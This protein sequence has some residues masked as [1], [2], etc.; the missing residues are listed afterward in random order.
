VIRIGEEKGIKKPGAL[1]V[2]K[3]RQDLNEVSLILFCETLALVEKLDLRSECGHRH[4]GS[5]S[6]QR[7]QRASDS[8]ISSVHPL[9]SFDIIDHQLEAPGFGRR[10]SAP[11]IMHV[12]LEIC[13]FVPRLERSHAGRIGHMHV[14]T[15]EVLADRS[16]LGSQDG[17][18]RVGV[19]AGSRANE[20]VQ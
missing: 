13:V 11:D 17:D 19:D 16:E 6:R 5:P 15:R 18:V 2:V 8:L 1:N 7:F 14:P 10:R 4:R 12:L 20:K 3:E 9:S